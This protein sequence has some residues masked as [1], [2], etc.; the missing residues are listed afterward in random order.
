MFAFRPSH[1]IPMSR[2]KFV[3]LWQISG[4]TC[5]LAVGATLAIIDNVRRG[6]SLLDSVLLVP[7]D[8]AF[9][10]AGV[11]LIAPLSVL[12]LWTWTKMVTRLP[13]LERSPL[14]A[15]VNLVLVALILA[16][17][18]GI[19]SHWEYLRPDTHG[20]AF[21]HDVFSVTKSVLFWC[22]IGVMLPRVLVRLLRPPMA[23]TRAD[24]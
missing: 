3:A 23:V 18:A 5:A 19:I 1:P 21:W 9:V 13:P 17:A 15:Y 4:M 16:F 6:I 8:L 20:N 7:S 12:V 2:W 10:L 14:R 11:V 22:C 24:A